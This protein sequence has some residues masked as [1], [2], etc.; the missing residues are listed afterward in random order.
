MKK[1]KPTSAARPSNDPITI[2]AIAP[3]DSP[4]F[5]V[6]EAAAAPVEDDVG[7]DVPELEEAVLVEKVMNPVMVGNTTPAQRDS[8]PEL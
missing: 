3:L 8:A 5:D 2:P 6:D 1:I 4:L 7:V